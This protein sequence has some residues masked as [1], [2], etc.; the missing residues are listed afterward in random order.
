MVCVK[1]LK[2]AKN[3]NWF[4]VLGFLCPLVVSIL[5]INRPYDSVPDQDLLWLSESLRL[6]RSAPPTYLDHPGSYWSL[7]YL[8]KLKLLSFKGIISFIS[9]RPGELIS[10]PDAS[11]IVRLSRIE[12]GIIC[13]L[14]S[15]S[16]WPI[17]R[18]SGVP[19]RLSGLMVLVYSSSSGLLWESVQI[20]NE[21]TSM[22]FVLTYINLSLLAV[23]VRRRKPLWA[24][25][26]SLISVA[27]FL[28]ALYCKIQVIFISI[29]AILFVI[30][31]SV[32]WQKLHLGRNLTKKFFL[33]FLLSISVCAL[34]WIGLTSNW[35]FAPDT[36]FFHRLTP[37]NI[38]LWTYIGLGMS[39]GVET[40]AGLLS[41][42]S[43]RWLFRTSLQIVFIEI[44]F[45]RV[46]FHPVWSAQVFL[47]PAS[48]L[49]AAT[50]EETGY[51]YNA[52]LYAGQIFPY[53]PGLF[54]GVF[55]LLFVLIL[56]QA[57][58]AASLDLLASLTFLLMALFVFAAT[59]A[60]LQFFYGIYYLPSFLL[61]IS[62]VFAISSARKEFRR[63][64][65]I[66]S[67][68]VTAGLVLGS[69]NSLS[70]FRDYQT[71][72]NTESHLCYAQQMDQ[73]MAN[74]SV[75]TCENFQLDMKR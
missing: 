69:I 2:S 70:S 18:V 57:I 56:F 29:F 20:R 8:L 1:M 9:T 65:R 24:R 37:L 33:D 75:G 13:G 3:L 16:L 62:S 45:A 22:L 50:L 74:T 54:I 47:L 10:I 44:L 36:P 11:L 14:L 68:I 31:S 49:G 28:F 51:L 60:R 48:L 72:N 41:S 4:L 21:S 26:L 64:M 40:C 5:A 58:F 71:L 34:G 12:Q 55:A 19:K 59:S 66:L 67:G 15:I 63:G 23:R 27:S 52:H 35:V 6:F 61:G 38:L 46:L 53:F 32:N 43:S 39:I 17:F 30:S 73:L 25:I 7:S 42:L